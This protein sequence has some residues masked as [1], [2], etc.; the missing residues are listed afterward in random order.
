MEAYNSYLIVCDFDGCLAATF[1]PSP[2]G[3]N[4]QEA[5]EY[6]IGSVFGKHGLEVY[7]KI[8]GLQNRAPREVVETLLANGNR[9]NLIENAGSFFCK[10]QTSLGGLIPKGKGY[11]L[12][13]KEGRFWDPGNVITEM[14]V[15]CKLSH[16]LGEISKEW[17][18]PYNG[19]LDFLETIGKINK[20]GQVDVQLAILSSGHEEFIKRTFSAWGF[21]CPQILVTD[22]DMRDRNY[23]RESWKRIKPSVVI[24][25]LVHLLWFAVKNGPI[26]DNLQLIRFLIETRSRMIYFGDDIAK[27]GKL[28]GVAGVPFGWFD[29]NSKL[30]N[31]PC[32]DDLFVFCDWQKMAKFFSKASTVKSFRE[33]R[34]FKEIVVPLY[35]SQ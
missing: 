4:V 27:D 30:L 28:A 12:E 6:A 32:N 2:R 17:P 8:G 11:P 24:F 29:P 25:D 14:L 26:A 16:L 1:E 22:D 15:R 18:R 31:R 9:E 10:K 20:D 33:G 3:R 35:R 7:K 34:S 19:V 5:Y 23:P 21:P 13:W